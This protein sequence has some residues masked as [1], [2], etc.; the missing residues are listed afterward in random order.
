MPA[1]SVIIPVFNVEPYMGRCARSL[2]SQTLE[3][4]EYIFIDDC[5]PDRSIEI[6]KTILDTE[7][8]NRKGQVRF[9]RM[10]VNSGQAAVRMQGI[11]M[12]SGDYVIHCDSDD[13]VLLPDAYKIL[14]EKASSEDLDIVTCNYETERDGVVLETVSGKCSSVAQMLKGEAKWNLC[15]Q[16]VRKSLFGEGFEAPVADMGEDMVISVQARLRAKRTGH[17]DQTFYRY[18]Y[19]DSSIMNSSGTEAQLSRWKSLLNNALLLIELLQSSYGY[20]GM[21]PEIMHLKYYC[22][23]YL[24]PFVQIPS[25]YQLWRNCFPEIDRLLLWSPAFSLEEKFWFVLIHLRLYY[26]VK[27]IMNR[28]KGRDQDRRSV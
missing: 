2:F 21:E 20:S 24:K 12:A 6:V 9:H 15:C 19:R 4:I 14:Y 23:F 25:Y 22:R 13:Y 28:M 3:D 17:I 16:L 8:P 10:P 1:V 27:R 11:S 5:S 7:Y 18:C 26:P